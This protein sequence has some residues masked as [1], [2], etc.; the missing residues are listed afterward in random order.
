VV[1]DSDE[2]EEEEQELVATPLEGTSRIIADEFFGMCQD[3]RASIAISEDGLTPI[4]NV[5]SPQQFPRFA[6]DNIPDIPIQGMFGNADA[7]SQL[8]GQVIRLARQSNLPRSN[9][10]AARGNGQHLPGYDHQ[11]AF[12]IRALDQMR[13][14]SKIG[15]AGE[16]FVSI[17][18]KTQYNSFN[19][20]LYRYMKYFCTLSS[21]ILV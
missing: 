13:H 19:M 4:S 2:D 18:P 10:S 12:G 8:L 3:R 5:S 16:L 11:T 17:I 1:S 9:F 21:R 20:K 15:A 14:D 6:Q 7:Y